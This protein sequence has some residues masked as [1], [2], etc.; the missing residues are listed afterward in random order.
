MTLGW[1]AAQTP[2]RAAIIMASSQTAVTYA[3]LEQR[4]AQ[5]ARALRSRGLRVGDHIALL[6]DNSPAFL[7]VAWAAQRSGL[8]YTAINRHLRRGEVSYVLDDCGAAALIASK[9]MADV[10][11]SLDLTRI[12][13]RVS[14]DGEIAGFE[15]YENVLAAESAAPL[16]DECEG[17]EMLYSSGTTGRP[18]GVRKPLPATPLGDPNAPPV[19]IAQGL[20]GARSEI[21]NTDDVVYLSPA[22]LYRS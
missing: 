5:F 22:P 7:E 4:S 2:D 13:V 11:A 17:R 10:V 6:M 16:D 18:K 15:R 21:K 19:Q 20:L 12:P 3:E 8:Y 1:H 9:A 14:A